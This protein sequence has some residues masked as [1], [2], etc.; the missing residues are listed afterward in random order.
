MVRFI[1]RCLPI[2]FLWSQE[3]IDAGHYRRY[4]IPSARRLLQQV[5]FDVVYSSYLFPFYRCLSSCC[6]L[7]PICQAPG[8]NL[9]ITGKTIQSSKS[10]AIVERLMSWELQRVKRQKPLL[11]EA[12][13]L[14]LPKRKG[15]CR[16]YRLALRKPKCA[17]QQ[18]LPARCH[19]SFFSTGSW[20]KWLALCV[21]I[22]YAH[23]MPDADTSL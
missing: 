5:G 17:T 14:L 3:D 9:P 16:I 7:C 22:P 8:T 13:V 21:Q 12:A 6:V 11:S 2:H 23:T 1:L 18:V 20:G 10:G 15:K 4:S 19:N